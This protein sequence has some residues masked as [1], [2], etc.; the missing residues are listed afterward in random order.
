MPR[1]TCRKTGLSLAVGGALALPLV[2]PELARKLGPPPVLSVV[3][4]VAA[5]VELV[6]V[7]VRPIDGRC[8]LQ[9]FDLLTAA[10]A[11]ALALVPGAAAGLGG[12]EAVLVLTLEQHLGGEVAVLLALA[13]RVITILGD[14]L[15]C[16][17][18][19]HVGTEAHATRSESRYVATMQCQRAYRHS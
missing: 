7:V 8:A 18:P 12:R 3:A 2:G 6:F 13:L 10:S 19:G 16:L 14:L 4:M 5:L 1:R 17:T 11:M 15:C 9:A